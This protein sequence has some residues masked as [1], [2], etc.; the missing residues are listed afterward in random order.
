LHLYEPNEL[1]MQRCSDLVNSNGTHTYRQV[2]LQWI[3]ITMAGQCIKYILSLGLR[4][5]HYG[6]PLGSVI[7]DPGLLAQLTGCG[8]MVN[9]NAVESPNQV[10][11]LTQDLITYT[12]L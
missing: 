4:V 7:F 11:F 1:A 5:L 10:E 9:M 6:I 8:D 3:A 12:K 2:T